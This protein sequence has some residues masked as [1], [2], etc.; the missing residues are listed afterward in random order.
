MRLLL[1]L[2]KEYLLHGKYMGIQ[3]LLFFLL[4]KKVLSIS[5]ISEYW[6]MVFSNMQTKQKLYDALLKSL[7][8][9]PN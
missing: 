8:H 1:K 9:V 5:V 2:Q 3:M 4:W 6:N 7:E